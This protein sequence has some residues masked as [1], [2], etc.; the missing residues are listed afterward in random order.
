[1]EI[2]PATLETVR[3]RLDMLADSRRECGFGPADRK[4]YEQLCDLERALLGTHRRVG[5]S[6]PT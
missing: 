4:E 1:M 3:H 6:R 2:Y 5:T